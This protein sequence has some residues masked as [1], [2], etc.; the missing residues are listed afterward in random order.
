MRCAVCRA[1]AKF[2]CAQ[3]RNGHYCG[4]SH[5]RI[6]WLRNHRIACIGSSRIGDPYDVDPESIMVIPD[7]WDTTGKTPLILGNELTLW[8]GELIGKGHWGRV[9]NACTDSYCKDRVVV[10]F[11]AFDESDVAQF[12]TEQQRFQREISI[13]RA[14]SKRD[15]GPKIFFAGTISRSEL[16][17]VVQTDFPTDSKLIGAIVMDKYDVDINQINQNDSTLFANPKNVQKVIDIMERKL[18]KMQKEIVH[19]DLFAKNILVKL[20]GD[21]IVDL[22]FTDF[23]L[24]YTNDKIDEFLQEMQFTVYRLRQTIFDAIG[25]TVLPILNADKESA[26]RDAL[27]K[28]VRRMNL[29]NDVEFDIAFSFEDDAKMFKTYQEQLRKNPHHVDTYGLKA[30]KAR[31]LN[32]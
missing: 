32:K 26:E 24:S 20:L 7:E 19:G 12:K 8:I 3:C 5:Q 4:I 30:F 17:N 14:M 27:K 18:E 11:Q 13:S 31:Y 23:G 21:Q 2:T 15:V 16:D 29:F 9:Y 1:E 22:A 10:K 28:Q 6:D 25:P